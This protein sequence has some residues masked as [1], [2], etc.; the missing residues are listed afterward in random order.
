MLVWLAQRGCALGNGPSPRAGPQGRGRNAS[1]RPAKAL[2]RPSSGAAHAVEGGSPCGPHH[3]EDPPKRLFS[4]L[5]QHGDALE[6]VLVVI[7]TAKKDELGHVTTITH[8]AVFRA[9]V[10]AGCC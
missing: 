8:H 10:S 6:T 1:T 5:S 2:S 3:T 7:V 9:R 4:L